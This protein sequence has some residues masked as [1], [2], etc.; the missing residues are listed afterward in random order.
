MNKTEELLRQKKQFDEFAGRTARRLS[1]Y[2]FSAVFLWK[3]FFEF[4]F[5]VID[6]HLCVW[7]RQSFGTFLY[8]PPLGAGLEQNTVEKCFE[9]LRSLNT[10]KGVGRIEN[11]TED[12]LSVF[13]GRYRSAKKSQEYYYLR[14]DIA[15]LKGNAFKSK[16]S[17]FNQFDKNHRHEFVRFDRQWTG[18]C[19]ELFDAWARDRAQRSQDDVF[20]LMLEENRKVHHLMFEFSDELGLEGRVVF[21]DGRPQAYSFGYSLNPDVFCVLVEVVN[22]DLKGL[23]VYI[24]SRFCADDALKSFQFINAMD[25]F[26]MENVAKTK[27]SFRPKFLVPSYT[28]TEK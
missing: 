14:E 20:K 19:L 5:E 6:D 12:G 9:R 26:A 7:A 11:L 8:L 28:V 3:D 27:A 22:L 18:D 21:V 24:F 17:S 2:H 15:G 13:D 4:S 1:V 10:R 16:R 25:D 23:S